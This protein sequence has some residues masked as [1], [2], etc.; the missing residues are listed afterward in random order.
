MSEN[1][2]AEYEKDDL[3]LSCSTSTQV[4]LDEEKV[5]T[6]LKD[7]LSEKEYSKIIKTKEYVDF[8]ALDNALY[9]HELTMKNAKS[10]TGIAHSTV[11]V[12]PAFRKTFLKAFN[13][14][15]VQLM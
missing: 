14:F 6:I 5:M 12:S 2:I 4:D 1:N 8:D 13:S 10:F 11:C 9:N 15:N 3:S 7:K